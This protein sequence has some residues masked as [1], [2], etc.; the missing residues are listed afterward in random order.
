MFRRLRILTSLQLS[1]RLNLKKYNNSTKIATSITIGLV[2]LIVLTALYCGIIYFLCDLIKIPKNQTILTFVLFIIQ[3]LSIIA[4]THGLNKTLYYGKDNMILLSYPANHHEVFLSKLL[5][6]Y[7]YEFI[8][9]FFFMFPLL[10]SIGIMFK[11]FSFFYILFMILF[12]FILPLFPVLISAILTIPIVLI[13]NLLKKISLIKEI[14]VCGILVLIFFLLIKVMEM[15]P[16]PLRIVALYNRFITNLTNFI[17]NVNKYSLFYNNIGKILFSENIL[18]NCL[19]IF[20]VLVG[21]ISL[22]VLLSM[23]LYF[24]LASKS[25][26]EANV[27]KHRNVNK[28]YKNVFFTFVRKEWTLTKR[29]IGDFVNNYIFMFAAPFVV[30]VMTSI[31]TAIDRNQL[32]MSL[33]TASIGLVVLMMS[34]ASNTSSA[35]AITQEGSEFVL[36]K[37]A[38]A[39]ATKMA[40]AKIF[41]NLLFST[42]MII[43]CFLIVTIFCDRLTDYVETW[44]LCGGVIIV[45]AALILWSFELDIK[46][47]SLREYAS[48]NDA[49][50]IK[51]VSTSIKIGLLLSFLYTAVVVLVLYLSP[52]LIANIV[53]IAV[54]LFFLGIRFFFFWNYLKY[55]FPKIEY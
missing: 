32:G 46:N 22:V 25:L 2:A 30:F 50:S 13:K 19:I 43:I 40:W 5:V 18:I 35:V 26:E 54:P 51:N 52:G 6:Y 27:K 48:N 1:D 15:I 31:I 4:C 45:N 47:P 9:N 14:G 17:V 44:I 55:V 39:D 21:L 36:L 33:T 29:N 38:P 16:V 49:T 34:S 10:V 28:A 41:F 8:K 53:I 37:T 20:G 12:M 3:I 24:K 7:V 23:P 11:I 42:I